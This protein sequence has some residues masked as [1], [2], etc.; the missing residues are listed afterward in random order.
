[1]RVESRG[2]RVLDGR[3][4]EKILPRGAYTFNGF[5]SEGV[6]SILVKKTPRVVFDELMKI[7][8]NAS[9]YNQEPV[10]FVLLVNEPD[11]WEKMFGKETKQKYFRGITSVGNRRAGDLV[12]EASTTAEQRIFGREWGK[13]VILFIE[14]LRQIYLQD[15]EATL[16]FEWFQR[17]ASI[18]GVYSVAVLPI[19]YEGK[20]GVWPDTFKRQII[21]PIERR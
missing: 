14:D 19:E 5:N 15:Y 10:R 16:S 9:V 11:K 18:Q 17:E 4:L 7:M 2:P 21:G 3:W 8:V 1:M 6:D 20:V 12:M 13:P